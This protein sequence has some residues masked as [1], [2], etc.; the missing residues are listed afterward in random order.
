[1]LVGKAGTGKTAM[2]LA[3]LDAFNKFTTRTTM[4]VSAVA[5]REL[6]MHDFN[7]WQLEAKLRRVEKSMI[8]VDVLVIDDFGSE[9]G[10]SGNGKQATERLQQFYMRIADARF[11]IDDD[12][13][14]TKSNIITTN[15]K[16]EELRE[17]YNDKLLSR[18][19]TKNQEN[20]LAF[21][22]LEDM[23]EFM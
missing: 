7:D 11:E 14:R 19:V 8:E 16:R 13:N 1:M 5:L 21:V 17:M 12:G 10:M 6:V 3:M 20:T 9:V 23:R 18:L 2:T 15:N 4:F 22:N